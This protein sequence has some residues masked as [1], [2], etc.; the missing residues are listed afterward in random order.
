MRLGDVHP[1]HRCVSLN[2]DFYSSQ[3][4]HTKTKL[5][6]GLEAS[7]Y[8]KDYSGPTA[9]SSRVSK[10]TRKGMARL[11]ILSDL[12]AK[13]SSRSSRITS[14]IVPLCP[15]AIILVPCKQ[16]IYNAF[17]NA[18]TACNK[19]WE[20]KFRS[21]CSFVVLLQPICRRSN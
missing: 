20:P 13:K 6:L 19:V 15:H 16:V 8:D 2:P 3:D 10:P 1:E 11:P 14:T 9:G 17:Q 7:F 21:V 4:G 12:S 5:S 18:S